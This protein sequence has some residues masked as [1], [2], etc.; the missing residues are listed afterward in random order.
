MTK[1]KLKLIFTEADDNIIEEFFS[2]WSKNAHKYGISTKHHEDMMLATLLAEVGKRLSP[3]RE[4]LNYSC[5]RLPQVFKFYRKNRK[6]ALADGRCNG[7][8]SSPK[9]IANKVYGAKYGNDNKD[10]GWTFRG[11]GFIQ[12]TFKNNFIVASGVINSLSN[13][14]ISA[15]ELASKIHKVKYALLSAMAFF[16][17]KKCWGCRTMNCMTDKVN[18]HTK[19]RKKRNTNYLRISKI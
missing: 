2:I 1:T 11:G 4:N 10:D 17:M 13:I 5:K 14:P 19:S 16:H 9:N 3:R 15:I 12:L 7:S 8:S 6:D 18:K